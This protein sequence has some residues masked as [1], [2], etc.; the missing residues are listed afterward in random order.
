MYPYVGR[1]GGWQ[2]PG[3]SVQLCLVHAAAVKHFDV[4]PVFMHKAQVP[5]QQ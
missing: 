1:P 5:A 4:Y 2:L 3:V